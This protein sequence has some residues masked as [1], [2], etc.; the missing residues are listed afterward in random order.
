[1]LGIRRG[2]PSPG[3]AKLR[4]PAPGQRTPPP[5][6]KAPEQPASSAA[7]PQPPAKK[8][9]SITGAAVLPAAAASAPSQSK[10]AVPAPPRKAAASKAVSFSRGVGGSSVA[11]ESLPGPVE[12]TDGQHRK[13]HPKPL[14]DCARC[15]YDKSRVL[16][17]QTYGSYDGL[18][19]ARGQRRVWLAPRPA[20]YGGKWGVGCICCAKFCESHLEKVAE[21][22]RSGTAMKKATSK[23]AQYANTKWARFEITKAEQIAVRGVRQH[24]QRLQHRRA[25][26]AMNAPPGAQACFTLDADDAEL[27]RGGV[28]QLGDWVQAWGS[29]RN[30]VSFSHAEKQGQVTSFVTGSRGQTAPRKAFAAMVRVMS[31]VLRL[32]TRARLRAATAISIGIDD[33]GAYRLIT[34]RCDTPC[35]AD[36]TAVSDWTGWASGCLGVLRRG[37]AASTKKL[38]DSDEDYSKA[39]A[40]SIVRAFRRIATNTDGV[41]D[42][43]V[44]IW[45]LNCVRIG[46]ADGAASAQKC[47]RF[48]ASGPMPNMLVIGR[49]LAHALRIAT[50]D[51]LLAVQEFDE[52]WSDVFDSKFALVPAIQNSEEWTEKLLLCQREVLGSRGEQGAGLKV[53]AKCL[54]YAKQRFDSAATPLRQFCCLLVAIAMLLAHTASDSRAKSEV[55]DRARRR[56]RELPRHVLT[57]GLCASY[58]EEGIRFVRMFDKSQHDPA[59]TWTQLMEFT[60]RM[61]LLFLEGHIWDSSDSPVGGSGSE[62]TLV[63]IA[64]HEAKNAPTIYYDDGRVARCYQTPSTADQQRLQTC[65]H[66]ATRAMLDRVEVELNLDH[67]MTLFTALDLKRWRQAF[68]LGRQGDSSKLDI[69]RRHA[70]RL[71]TVWRLDSDASMA[72][73]EGVVAKLA[74]DNRQSIDG[75]KLEDN[76]AIWVQALRPNFGPNINRVEVLIRI[77][78]AALDGTCGVERDL[79]ALTRV[80]RAHS[81]PTDEDG[82][83][84]SHCITI[85]LDGPDREEELAKQPEGVEASGSSHA[86]L[87]LP[88]DFSRDCVRLWTACH[89]RRFLVYKPGRGGCKRGPKPGTMSAVVRGVAHATNRIVKQAT[90]GN[91]AD[92][93]VLGVPRAVLIKRDSLPTPSKKLQKFMSLTVVKR[94]RL[95]AVAQARSVTRSTHRSPFLIGELNPNRKLRRGKVLTAPPKPDRSAPAI[96]PAGGIVVVASCC[97]EVVPPTPGYRI[98]TPESASSTAT[99]LQQLMGAHIIVWDAS[100]QLDG[101]VKEKHLLSAI[102]AIGMGKAVLARP[103]WRGPRPHN[104]TSLIQYL[105]AAQATLTLGG[106]LSDKHAAV[107]TALRTVA[108]RRTQQWTIV[109]GAAAEKATKLFTLAAVR[110]FLQQSRRVYTR[111][112]GMVTTLI[113]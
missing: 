48:L 70:R 26:R 47:L 24:E 4:S 55:R 96:D 69:L 10:A 94:Q 95:A 16:L 78:M 42:E 79:G 81:G 80:L 56:L 91:G 72:Q 14:A 97:T 107:C 64:L 43:S 112:P 49:D 1:M 61:R 41:C 54:Q 77:Y 30:P 66:Q 19:G 76:R 71:F 99:T 17:E 33:R 110:D 93:T 44:V 35:P 100:W 98:V 13:R 85:L 31:F 38:E 108:A 40:E 32:R 104:S 7:R 3:L 83:T 84:I 21:V 68:T 75:G 5:K 88:T 109:Q 62:K 37:G 58:A 18:G 101:P 15:Q 59:R 45:M 82:E 52:W 113:R 63:E 51:S 25:V 65:V 27:F 89:G 86:Q 2:S 6:R 11:Q 105:P 60:E 8:A 28:P 9:R 111:R 12:E 22:K 87:L 23:G 57:V 73:L 46:V 74:Q 103:R 50:R 106:E 102:V 53:V 67:A 20:R 92:K 90:E 36:H 29:C 34:Y 39:M